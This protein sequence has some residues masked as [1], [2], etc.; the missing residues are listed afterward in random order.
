VAN[1]DS[2]HRPASN[3][4]FPDELP[5]LASLIAKPS[6]SHAALEPPILLSPEGGNLTPAPGV[7]FAGFSW[8]PSSSEGE[9][10]EIAKFASRGDS[11]LVVIFPS[12]SPPETEHLSSGILMAAPGP[13]LWRVWSNFG[14]WR[15]HIFFDAVI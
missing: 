7:R 10:A 6:M 5:V 11:R 2:Q 12:A 4:A 9:G 15:G 1:A 13:W 8:H 14:V 3:T